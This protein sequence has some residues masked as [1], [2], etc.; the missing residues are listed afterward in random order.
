MPGEQPRVGPE[1]LVEEVLEGEGAP[2][3]VGV[4]RVERGL[5]LALLE[6]GDDRGRVADVAAVDGQHR[7]GDLGAAGEPERERDVAA[8]RRRAPLVLDAL[9][10]QGP[11]R[12]LAVVRDGDVPE[13][14]EAAAHCL[15]P[16]AL[17]A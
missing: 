8:G 14:G 17:P 4:G 7:E 2:A 12:L 1:L 11:A 10:G 9:V 15:I 3:L 5:G 16:A 6:R 13:G